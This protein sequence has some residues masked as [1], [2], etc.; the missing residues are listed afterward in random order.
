MKNGRK[1]TVKQCKL[2]TLH[3]KDYRDWLVIKISPDTVTFRHR[4]TNE[5][6]VIDTNS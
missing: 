4:I 5:I 2:L 3:N 6:L 1:P